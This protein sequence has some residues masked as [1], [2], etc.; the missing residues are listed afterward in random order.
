MRI[1]LILTGLFII[2]STNAQ[3]INGS[4]ENGAYGWNV[5]CECAPASFSSDVAPG[6]GN[7]CIGLENVHLDCGCMLQSVVSQPTPWVTPGTWRLSGWIKSAV[8]E[9]VPGSRITLSDGALFSTPAVVNIWSFAGQWEYVEATFGVEDFINTD[10][11][12]VSLVPDDGNQQPLTLCYFD[13]IQL[14]SPQG[15]GA[16][17]GAVQTLHIRPNPTTDK[18]WVDLA[19]APLSITATDPIGRMHS[20]KNSAY[21]ARTLEVDVNELDPG[22]WVLHI[23]TGSG[24]YSIRFIKQ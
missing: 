5:P 20:L 7:Q 8:P 24:S 6:T 22:I 4:F 16:D 1:Q 12:R 18:L 14:S 13:D 15:I 10:S 21:R 3:L 2:G 23:S 9:D 11:L 19:D 17:A